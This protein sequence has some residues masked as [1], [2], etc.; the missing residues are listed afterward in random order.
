M[1]FQFKVQQYQTDAVHAVVNVFQRQGKNSPAYRMDMGTRRPAMQN[2]PIQNND[3]DEEDGIG[4]KNSEITLSAEQLLENIQETQLMHAVVPSQKLDTSL[5][6]CCLDVEMETGTGK[7]YVYI[8]TIFE[9]HRKYGWSKFIIVVPS[10]AIREGVKKSLEIM[11]QHFFEEYQEK[12]RFFVYN[13]SNLHDIDTFSKNPKINVMII[14]TQAFAASLKEGG[15]SKESRII[16]SVRDDFNS[17]R[18]IDVIK[19]NSPILILDEPQ[20]MGGKAT[21]EALQ[22]FNPLFSINYSATH[23]ARH[24]LVYVLDALDAYNKRLVKKIEVKGFEQKNHMGVNGYVYL[25][26]IDIHPNRPPRAMLEIEVKQASG[27]TV[28]KSFMFDKGDDLHKKSPMAQ[29]EKNFTILDIG[30]DAFGVGK[31][32]F[33][34]GLVLV[35]GQAVG[36]SSERAMRRIQIRETIAS[37]FEK[38]EAL[39]YKGIK[40]LSLFFIDE[41]AKYREYDENNTQLLGE[42][43]KMF[44]EEYL[45]AYNEKA[46]SLQNT[47]YLKYLR[48]ISADMGKVHN[49]YFSIDKKTGKSI[50]SELKKGME[51]SD[52]MSAYDLI[53]KNKERLLSFEEPT[54]FIFSHS[55]LREGWDNPNI[56]QICTLKHSDSQTAKRQEVGRGLRLCVDKNGNRMDMETLGSSVHDINVLTVVASESYADFVKD[57]QNDMAETL[58]DRP[59][60][61]TVDFFVGKEIPI[62]GLKLPINRET[63]I[64]LVDN[65]KKLDYLDE[66]GNITTTYNQDK[67]NQNIAKLSGELKQISESI[68]GFIDTVLENVASLN[69]LIENGHKVKA[70]ENTINQANFGKKEFK[71][72]W[73]QINHKYAYIV[74]F[75]SDELINKAVKAL[76]SELDVA[77]FSY[78]RTVSKQKESL[79]K[80]DIEQNSSFEQA[81]NKTQ[82][83]TYDDVNLVKY[84]LVGDIA[85]QAVLTR[86]TVVKI[87]KGIADKTFSLFKENPEEFIAKTAKIIK[88]QK[89][90]MIVEHIAYN[91]T[92]ETYDTSIFTQEKTIKSLDRAYQAKK[93]I[94]EYVL[95]DGAASGTFADGTENAPKDNNEIRFAKELDSAEEVAV[96][97]KLPRDFKIPT[98][99]GD[100]TPDWAIAFEKGTVKHVFFIAETKGNLDTLDLRPIEKAKITCAKK[101]FNELST[102]K[103]RYHEATNYQNLL[104][105][106]GKIE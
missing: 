95:T 91:K 38:E 86:K 89:A 52:D 103:V 58:Y 33:Q 9:L 41:V 66:Q 48:K 75:D 23:K 8:K 7:T 47:P 64:Q 45:K 62:A 54:R 105:V 26:R 25:D 2:L 106:M 16:Y 12:I 94:L 5:G 57:L 65:L 88:E 90:S 67:K 85:K 84:D 10:I 72:L 74:Q 73:E 53:L 87:L 80:K 29:Y 19:A 55:A 93:H 42:Y 92:E 77:K 40:T 98:P 32:E 68:F 101:L 60:K 61:I 49:G 27:K 22:N 20:K 14:N 37:H 82:T 44:E 18:P 69:T 13:S 104:E 97:A 78:T 96:Y 43:G 102:S 99:V 56:F 3:E 76:D 35:K 81:K 11:Q 17:R 100:Y 70:P 30:Y 15:R 1:Q 79:E 39:F 31:V 59:Q 83:L 46:N 24:N 34:N 63:A 50:D 36:D 71:E 51:F 28:R 21:Q 6:A 4:Y